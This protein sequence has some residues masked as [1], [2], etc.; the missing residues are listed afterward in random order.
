MF[1]EYRHFFLLIIGL[2][3]IPKALANVYELTPTKLSL[4]AR[5]M[6][7]VVKV[8]NK[9]DESSL[10]QLSLLDWQQSHGK[11]I[12]EI[13]H[14]ILMTPPLFKLP[15]HKTQV[16]RFALKHPI[17][18]TE[19]KAYRLHIKE[20]QQ[21]RKKRLGQTLYF[22]M[23]LSLPLFIQ[24]QHIVEQFIWSAKRLD[25]KHVQLKLYNDGNVSLFISQ[26]QLL[27]ME[28]QQDIIMKKHSTFVNIFPHQS[29]SWKLN[30]DSSF[31]LTEIK[32]NINGQSKKSVLQL[33]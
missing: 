7:G 9:S 1:M 27:P 21:P 28:Q 2:I 33:L 13:S 11:D 10:L 14:D 17:F 4:S 23:D 6:V 32:S 16:I 31:K 18:N 22:L 25:S 20:V 29:H 3:L 19:Q 15:P 26:W 12:Y 24:P 8:T 5:Q 30:L